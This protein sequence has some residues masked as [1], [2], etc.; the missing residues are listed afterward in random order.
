MGSRSTSWNAETGA[1]PSGMSPK[2]R[3][4]LENYV[5]GR[6]SR[7]EALLYWLSDRLLK[8]PPRRVEIPEFAD[9]LASC[10][11]EMRAGEL[12]AAIVQ[13][14]DANRPSSPPFPLEV[15]FARRGGAGRLRV[16][17]KA[18]T[19][20]P[21]CTPPDTST[22]QIVCHRIIRLQRAASATM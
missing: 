13:V 19:L 11:L 9:E 7:C 14:S 16:E 22:A 1:T 10:L 21:M 20:A 18:L 6:A 15:A 17:P 12:S 3:P 2:R 5:S 4:C 8:D